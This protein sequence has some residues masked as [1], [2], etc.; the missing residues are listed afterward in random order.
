MNMYITDT[1]QNEWHYGELIG[2][3]MRQNKNQH[4]IC[5]DTLGESDEWLNL[6]VCGCCRVCCRVC[7]GVLQWCCSGV[8]V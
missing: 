5:W 7:C 4:R 3:R 1:G 8:A 2:H 6:Q